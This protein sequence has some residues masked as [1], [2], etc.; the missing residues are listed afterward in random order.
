[1][2]IHMHTHTLTQIHTHTIHTNIHIHS[3]ILTENPNEIDIIYAI[4]DKIAI[5][6]EAIPTGLL[7]N[8]PKAIVDG[9]G[10]A[11]ALTTVQTSLLQQIEK[12]YEGDF[13]LRRQMLMKR[14]DVTIQSFLWGES[15][16]GK[17]EF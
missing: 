3:F 5:V 4:C 7:T 14:L 17:L 13:K 9:A 2:H 6:S 16:Q 15:A 1:M 11:A 8:P 12:A 10:K